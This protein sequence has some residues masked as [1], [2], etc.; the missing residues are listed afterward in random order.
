MYSNSHQLRTYVQPKSL[1]LTK[2]AVT[3]IVTPGFKR[4]F[5]FLQQQH[6]AGSL[7]LNEETYTDV[8]LIKHLLN[9]F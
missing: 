1:V 7:R 3:Y 8:Q 6:D 5:A 2:D 9:H 4:F